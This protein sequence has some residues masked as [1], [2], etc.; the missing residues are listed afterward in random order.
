MPDV[1]STCV[2]N[3]RSDTQTLPTRAML[4]A[5][6]SAPLGDDTY[7]EDPTVRRLEALSAERFGKE[8]GLF[9]LSGTMGNLVCL[10]AQTNPG[11]EVIL[12]AESHLFY[13]ESGGLAS[14]A[15]LMPMPVASDRGW[16]DPRD[17]RNCI[18]ACDIH[19]PVPRIFCLENTHNRGGG[20]VIPFA[21]HRELCQI[22]REHGLS[23][24][25]DG[26]RIFNAAIA[27]KTTVLE[28]AS[29]VDTVMFCL[30]K[31]LSCPMG[32]VVVGSSEFISRA[33]QI[34]KR[35]G[36]GMRQ[37][38]VAAAA[39]IVALEEM[40]ERL[41]DDHFHAK[42]LAEGISDIPGLSVDVSSV[43]TN[44]VYVDHTSTGV[45]TENIVERLRNCGVIA[46]GR[47][48][49]QLRFVTNRHHDSAT[50]QEALRRIRAAVVDNR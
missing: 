49:D 36:G 38:G 39:G 35:L 6:C 50:I 9:V 17:L 42:L 47:P 15:G 48:P 23:I 27:T 37:A 43:D 18:R 30:T 44:M 14:V 46:D 4:E 22:A 13:Y 16:I 28:Y 3:L 7:G 19:F 8:A 40:I 10:M 45:S 20:R 1:N 29:T 21:L 34:R 11:D 33:R 12:D 24:H 25:L 41:A 2:I 5:M 31:G 32:S 26:A